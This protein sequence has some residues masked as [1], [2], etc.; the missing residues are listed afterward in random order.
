MDAMTYRDDREAL[1]HRVAQLEQELQ[2]AR[3]EGEEG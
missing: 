1:H 2:D 3:R